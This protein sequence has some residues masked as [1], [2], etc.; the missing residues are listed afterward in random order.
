VPALLGRVASSVA[1]VAAEVVA[2]VDVVAVRRRAVHDD[3]EVAIRQGRSRGHV[4]RLATEYAELAAVNVPEAGERGCRG[5]DTSSTERTTMSTSTMGF[6]ARPGT[7]VEP[8]CSTYAPAGRC[9]S[10]AE[11]I[12][13]NA[14]G[15]A[16]SYSRLGR[17]GAG[18]P[19]HAGHGVIVPYL[20]AGDRSA[21]LVRVP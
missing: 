3:V 5:P 13:P 1:R 20:P 11:R 21:Q 18:L 12:A 2:E 8:T 19:R 4:E 7:A 16:G 10:I 6:A 17:S 14:A 9:A 15:H